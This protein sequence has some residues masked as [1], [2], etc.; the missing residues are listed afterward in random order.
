MAQ[1]HRLTES[2]IYQFEKH[3]SWPLL[4]VFQ[5][6][7][8]AFILTN[9]YKLDPVR[10]KYNSHVYRRRLAQLIAW[11]V[12]TISE[13]TSSRFSFDIS[14][15]I[16]TYLE[17]RI[18]FEDDDSSIFKYFFESLEVQTVTADVIPKTFCNEPVWE[19]DYFSDYIIPL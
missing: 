6:L 10:L 15:D 9:Y 19:T 17:F 16:C 8:D 13:Y 2:L 4:S 3:L 18:N 1:Y 5:K 12:G 7:S 11:D 14:E